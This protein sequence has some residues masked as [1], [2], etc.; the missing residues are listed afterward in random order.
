MFW[1]EVER[2]ASEMC[3][4]SAFFRLSPFAVDIEGIVDQV[5]VTGGNVIRSLSS[6][7]ESIWLDYKR[8]GVQKLKHAERCN[9]TVTVDECG[10]KLENFLAIYYGTMQR[11]QALE[12]YYFPKE[13]F[14]T[15]INHLPGQFA[16]IHVM[17]DQ[18]VVASKLL[19][20]SADNVYG[21]LGGADESF[22]CMNAYDFVTHSAIM[23]G[24]DHK[25]KNYVL[26]GGYCGYDGIFQFKKKFAPSGVVP[27]QVG[28]HIF[29]RTIYENMCD[30]RRKYEES[31]GR[32]LI[33]C[34]S[35]FPAYRTKED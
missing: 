2:W 16:F 5:S 9:L 23:W 25:K 13:F 4:I 27:F 21:F 7:K 26:G 20:V 22:F 19:L 15:I 12:Q 6:D 29:D 35:F 3:L 10:K 11:R 14:T 28:K 8:Q 33:G 32:Y 18:T 17:H 34:D 1:R 31:N 24:V 30:K